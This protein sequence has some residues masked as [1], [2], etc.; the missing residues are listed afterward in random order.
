MEEIEYRESHDE[1]YGTVHI[2][3]TE[4]GELEILTV[5]DDRYQMERR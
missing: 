4:T 3:D 2:M 1:D 5:N